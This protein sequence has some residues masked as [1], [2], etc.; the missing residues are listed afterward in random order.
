MQIH[1]DLCTQKEPHVP[2]QMVAAPDATTK[3][4]QLAIKEP[5]ATFLGK[6]VSTPPAEA[7]RLVF[8]YIRREGL[9]VAEKEGYMRANAKICELCEATYEEGYPDDRK[10]KAGCTIRTNALARRIREHLIAPVSYTHL[11][12]PT[13]CSV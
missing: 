4:D 6:G 1:Q 2:P 8:E 5:L 12:L 3:S 7:L 11:T 10:A 13:I 9:L